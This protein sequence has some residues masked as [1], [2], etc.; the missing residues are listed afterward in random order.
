M[1]PFDY[2]KFSFRGNTESIP[3][4]SFSY[5]HFI[6]IGVGVIGSILIIVNKEK[7]K[8]GRFRYKIEKIFLYV[9]ISQQTLLYLWY[10]YS[11][12]LSNE[13]LPLY[14]CRVAIIFTII[15]LITDKKLFKIVASY[16]GLV[17]SVLALIFLGLDPFLFPHFTIFS[18]FIGHLFLLWISVY[19]LATE[20]IILNKGSLKEILIFT[21]IYNVSVFIFN[22]CTN[23]NYSYLS[24]PPF[25]K[26][27]ILSRLNP[28][29]YTLGIIL[30]FNLVMFV[31]YYMM[32]KIY[33][34]NYK[35]IKALDR[36][37]I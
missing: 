30:A 13:S 17:G 8:I 10:G 19:F 7:L 20:T 1:R 33:F 22:C 24:E 36:V 6:L 18:Y 3:F 26:E 9:L 31:I 14:H 21:N 25:L 2:I 11:G 16:W 27:L 5:I 32:Q 15:A 28:I 34:R 4:E 37:Y 23:A 12:N 35:K 29:M